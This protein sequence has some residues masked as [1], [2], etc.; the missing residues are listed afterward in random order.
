MPLRNVG[1]L[2]MDYTALY[3]TFHIH[4]CENLKS[5]VICQKLA[6]APG[7]F[8]SAYV[9]WLGHN[10]ESGDWN[11]RA[12]E[13]VDFDIRTENA[14][15][16]YFIYFAWKVVYY[17]VL[18]VFGVIYYSRCYSVRLLSPWLSVALD[19]KGNRAYNNATFHVC[20]LFFAVDSTWN[21]NILRHL[22]RTNMYGNHGGWSDIQIL[23]QRFACNSN[24][25]SYIF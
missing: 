25:H 1:L 14:M 23:R 4:R 20:F 3:G 8:R 2:S 18:P 5:Y 21:T 22:L 9:S 19:V 6:N 11:I 17:F 12:H 13:I 16:N 15:N 7:L 10:H 24:P